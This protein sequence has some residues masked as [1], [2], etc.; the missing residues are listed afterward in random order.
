MELKSKFIKWR[1]YR[2]LIYFQRYF[3]SALRAVAEKKLSRLI[4]KR[5]RLFWTVH[6]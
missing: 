2:Q 5:S 1:T 4:N 6:L 3:L